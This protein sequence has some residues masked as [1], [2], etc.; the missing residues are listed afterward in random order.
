MRLKRIKLSGFKSFADSTSITFKSN[1]TAVVGPNG[2]G[3]SN[4]I[5]AVRWVMGEISAKQLRGEMMA[6]VIFSG[7]NSRKSVG[8][9]STELF[10]DNTNS[11]LNGEY[12]SYSEIAI[13][14]EVNRDGASNYYLNGT[15]CRRK[16]I[17]DI[18]LGTG[19]GPRSYAIIEQGM[20]SDLIEAKPDEL[21]VFF[22]EAAG[23]SKYKERR[24]ETQ[25]RIERT[26]DNLA[27]LN[28]IRTEL[29][30]QLRHLK[31]QANMANRY[32]KLKEEQR[33]LKAQLQGLRWRTV[34]DEMQQQEANI[35]QQE[36]DLEAGQTKTNQLN[37]EIEA[38]RQQ[39]IA[40]HDELNEVQKRYYSLG[41]E[42]AKHEQQMQHNK[43]RLSQLSQD[44]LDVKQ[45]LEELQKHNNND[46]H[47]V[48][49]IT[50]ALEALKQQSQEANAQTEAAKTKSND[51][52]QEMQAW[53]TTWDEFNLAAAQN[54]KQVDINQAKINHLEQQVQNDTAKLENCRQENQEL[55][56]IAALEN[57]IAELQQQSEKA[58]TQKQELTENLQANQVSVAEN[59]ELITQLATE[60]DNSKH[61]L[62]KLHGKLMSLETLQQTALGKAD[63]HVQT[64]LSKNDLVEKTRLAEQLQVAAGWEKAVET[65]LNNYLEAVCVD[66]LGQLAA[67]LEQL[68]SGNVALFDAAAANAITAPENTLASKVESKLAIN[69][70][71]TNIYIAEDLPAAL[72]LRD[73]LKAHESVI[74]KSGVWLG[75]FWA[76]INSSKD[77]KS[78]VVQ[79]ER[80][81]KE[82]KQQIESAQA[83]IVQQEQDL[84]QRKDTRS[85]LETKREQLQQ[86][87]SE[88][89][90]AYTD[91]YSKLTVNQN[92]LQNIS[93]RSKNLTAEITGY[94][95]RIV[96]AQEQLSDL[97]NELQQVQQV[98]VVDTEQRTK[99]VNDRDS[100]REQLQLAREHF[101]TVKQT[102]DSCN[103]N[104]EVA[105]N[106]LQYLQQSLARAESQLTSL[107]ER[108]A[109]MQR[110]MQTNQEPLDELNKTLQQTLEQRVK[111]EQELT[112]ARQNLNKS[113]YLLQSQEQQR[114]ELQQQEQKLRDKLE[115]SRMEWQALQVRGTTYEE[116]IVAGGAEL[117]TIL[118]D[119][120]EDAEFSEWAG[121]LEKISAK[122]EKLGPINLAAINEYEQT[123]TRKEYLDTQNDDL[124]QAL[125]TLTG[126]MHK[127]DHETRMRFKNTF[128]KVNTEF[129]RLFP[130]VFGGGKATLT[131]TEDDLLNAGITI[132]AQPP[133][134]KNTTIHLLSGG[135]K[136]L[137][138]IALVFAIFQLNPAPFCMLDEVDAPLDDNNILRFSNL[139]KEM[140]DT[141][142]FIVVTHNK[143]TMELADQLLGVTMYEP[144]VSRM[145]SVDIDQAVSMAER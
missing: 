31:R 91:V 79:R 121:K 106:K 104:I 63:T 89:T 26:R 108:Q 43:D 127:I 64:W 86:Q 72:T 100:Y 65:V 105:N 110:Q 30:G 78:G 42:I 69:N 119:L 20:I 136:A 60:L 62:Q 21:R 19:L 7:T 80:D 131:M 44:L 4:I 87:L 16:D 99:L 74:T 117:E 66:D 37:T 47:E 138:A 112:E 28:D 129:A 113:E 1:R 95:Q 134:K 103:T 128:E 36:L 34:N 90:A 101:A 23:I 25:N 143:T 3:K 41:A 29:E 141:V 22:E 122:I 38:S 124:V 109:S 27:R 73:N 114:I 118:S 140:S 17:V 8:Q 123:L 133:G 57:E 81:L 15:K 76:S 132:L 56:V 32:K 9:A 111:V 75:P 92:Q 130:I 94:E 145:V 102:A 53:Q 10:F 77:A 126:A 46:Q 18:F 71:L 12:A 51:A 45:S 82:T 115:Q 84:Q 33:L 11:V 135:E 83:N 54:S 97:Q 35:K 120:P 85:Q 96:L 48:K 49:T 39:Q 98:G 144:G 116:Q 61:E 6:D 24:R 137:T 125:D 88:I 70:L 2:C 55:P 50:V 14:R 107:K 59:R 52:E 67:L 68:E 93:E 139:V 13:R 142:Q 58:Q 5:D 40:A